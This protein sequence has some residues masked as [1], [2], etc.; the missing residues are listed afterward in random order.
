MTQ[1]PPTDQEELL[2]RIREDLLDSYD[3]EL[4]METEDR[5]IDELEAAAGARTPAPSTAG[6]IS[7]SS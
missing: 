1:N 2:R 3:E 5:S 4:E 7:A 6:P